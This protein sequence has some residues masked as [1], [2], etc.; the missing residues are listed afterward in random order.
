MFIIYILNYLLTDSNYYWHIKTI[1]EN[2]IKFG[3]DSLNS[4]FR[5][6]NASLNSISM[7]QL[8]NYREL[9]FIIDIENRKKSIIYL[10][11]NNE[12]GK[13]IN[14]L[15]IYISNILKGKKQNSQ[16]LF[17]FINSLKTNLQNIKNEYDTTIENK[18]PNSF[19]YFNK[20]IR[21]INRKIQEAFYDF[22]LNIISI[23][24]KFHEFN[25]SSSSIEKEKNDVSFID[26]EEKFFF[27]TFFYKQ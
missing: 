16:F 6:V 14:L 17:N 26:T 1:S 27:L 3:E 19:F 13:N 8:E 2:E 25:I 15:L 10:D 4:F 11:N 5:G 21:R 23:I 9:Y 22:N 18:A 12:E 7:N 20:D 24:Y